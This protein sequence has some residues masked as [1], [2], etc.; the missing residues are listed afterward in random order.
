MVVL[1]PETSA[2][3]IERMTAQRRTD[4]AQVLATD[5][6]GTL[7]DGDVAID[8]FETLLGERAVRSEATSSL[9]ALCDRL[10][11]PNEGAPT[12]LA[13]RLYDAYRQGALAEETSCELMGWA[14]A[15]FTYAEVLAFATRALGA[16]GLRSRIVGEMQPILAWARSSALPIVVVSASPVP[17]VEA[18][19]RLAGI[20][21]QAIRGT[22]P[23]VQDGVLR[24][25][26]ERPIPY[27]PGKVKALRAEVAMTPVLGAFGDSSFDV[28]LLQIAAVAAAVRPKPGLLARAHERAGLVR[29]TP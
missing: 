22:R 11:L 24:A 18:G 28:D 27:G 6:D 7:W 14:F 29:L 21:V 5:A 23:V 13:R 20:S 17:I 8:V 3:V 15:G 25:A 4:V 10:G 19:L 1:P 26:V 12:V 16:R 2:R 9:V